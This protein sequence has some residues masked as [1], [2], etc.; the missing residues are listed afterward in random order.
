[1]AWWQQLGWTA[2]FALMLLVATGGN[3]IVLWIVLG[4]L[5]SC[6]LSAFLSPPLSSFP[7]H[8]SPFPSSVLFISSYFFVHFKLLFVCSSPAH[9]MRV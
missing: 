5:L 8:Y 4:E 9:F 3:A 6:Y 2:L 7:S 1:M